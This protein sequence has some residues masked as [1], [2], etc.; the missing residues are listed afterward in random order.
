MSI[1]ERLQKLEK[2]VEDL[3]VENKELLARLDELEDDHIDLL[4]RYCLCNNDGGDNSS[5]ESVLHYCIC[6]K[7]KERSYDC[8]AKT[9]NE[10]GHTCI[11]LH[12]VKNG[13]ECVKRIKWCR[14]HNDEFVEEVVVIEEKHILK[15]FNARIFMRQFLARIKHKKN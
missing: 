6:N 3:T 8:R 7:L 15:K 13:K 4:L 12:E 11:C 5:C 1:E 14:G 10:N 9:Y 2:L